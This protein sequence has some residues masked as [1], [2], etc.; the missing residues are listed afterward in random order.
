M[1]A[2]KQEEELSNL[3][4]CS[5][6]LS[7]KYI[8]NLNISSLIVSS[9]WPE[10][11][12]AFVITENCTGDSD[13]NSLSFLLLHDGK[14][15]LQ[16]SH[17][18]NNDHWFWQYWS[19][20]TSDRHIYFLNASHYMCKKIKFAIFPKYISSWVVVN[21]SFYKWEQRILQC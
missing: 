3:A 21:S 4:T 12:R 9:Y 13:G 16:A 1:K 17:F 14:W 18:G 5:R 7:L 10:S 8:C 11:P 2:E 15:V 20:V 19:W 6:I